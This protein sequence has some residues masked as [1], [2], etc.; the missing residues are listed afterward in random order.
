VNF[1][2]SEPFYC[3]TTLK[4]DSSDSDSTDG[5]QFFKSYEKAKIYYNEL[6]QQKDKNVW[7]AELGFHELN[8]GR[9]AAD[10]MYFRISKAKL[11]DDLKVENSL[12]EYRG[13]GIPEA[14]GWSYVAHYK[15]ISSL[16]KP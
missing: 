8:S 3:C 12:R 15:I 13:H 11:W 16:E 2:F 6:L 7:F 5:E 14:S 1:D 10:W 9:L 4:S